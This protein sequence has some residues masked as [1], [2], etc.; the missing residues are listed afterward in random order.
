MSK[1]NL[2]Q[3]QTECCEVSRPSKSEMYYP[4]MHISDTKLPIDPDEIGNVVT[5][6]VKLKFEGMRQSK[7]SSGKDSSSYDFEV[8]EIEF[9]PKKKKGGK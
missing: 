2:G 9:S 1:V 7:R 5:A 3:K 6:T 4:S 8:H